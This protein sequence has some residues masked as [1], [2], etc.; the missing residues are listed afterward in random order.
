MSSTS[1][2]LMHYTD[3]NE[4]KIKMRK[5]F[6]YPIRN[7]AAYFLSVKCIKLKDVVHLTINPK[8]Y[9]LADCWWHPV[10]GD[11]HVGPHVHPG[12]LPQLKDGPRHLLSWNIRYLY[13]NQGTK[14]RYWMNS[15]NGLFG[16]LISWLTLRVSRPSINCEHWI[17]HHHHRI[18][19]VH[20]HWPINRHQEYNFMF[21]K[22][23]TRPKAGQHLDPNLE[24]GLLDL[25]LIVSQSPI[26]GIS[27]FLFN[28]QGNPV[29]CVP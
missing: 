21:S 1:Y 11:A 22:E 18:R 26:I 14:N 7:A 12:D 28:L 16:M 17:E 27:I 24:I 29:S 20:W 19:L 25:D 2:N 10:P 5:F 13:S 8:L 3:D 15:E 23:N 4:W 9:P 6:S